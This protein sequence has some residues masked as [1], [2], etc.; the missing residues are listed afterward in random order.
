MK[1]RK[2]VAPAA[3]NMSSYILRRILSFIL[4]IALSG[5]LVFAQQKAYDITVT[6]ATIETVFKMIEQKGEYTISFNAADINKQGLVSF[7][8]TQGSVRAVLDKCL[9]NTNL[10]YEFRGTAIII[11]EKSVPQTVLTGQVKDE[12]G[13][14]MIGVTLVMKGTQLGAATDA[15]GNY[16]LRVPNKKGGVIVASFVGFKTKEVAYTGQKVLNIN[17]AEDTKM[18]EDVVI[19]GYQSINKNALTSSIATITNKELEKLGTLSIDQMLE[20]K[21]TG[22]MVTN[23]N[24]TPGAAAKVRVRSGGTFTGSREPLWVIDGVI[25]ED[26]VPLSADQIN[27]FDNVNIIGNALTGINPQDIETI[28]VLKD[29]SA[30]AIYGTRAANGVIVISTKRGT[31]GSCSLN[32]SGSTSFVD[33]PRYS[34]FEL[35][36]SKERIDVSREIREKNLGYPSNKFSGVGYEGALQEY[37]SHQ[38]NFG[39]FQARVSQMEV[40]N[41]DW[42]KALYR[43]AINQTHSVNASGGAD[44]IRYY[45]SVGYDNQKG[46]EKNVGLNRVTGR[47]NV[48]L[49]IKKNLLISF[50]ASGSVQEAKYNHSSVK[51]FN[52]AYYNSRTMPYQKENGELYYVQKEIATNNGT[53]IYGNRNILHEMNNSERNVKNQEFNLNAKIK[54][55]I[56]KGLKFQGFASYRSTNNMQDEWIQENTFYVSR[57]RT[58]E[59]LSDKD[60]VQISKY[61]TVPF[62]GLYSAGSVYS[63]SFMGRAELNANKSI[64][65]HHFFTLNLGYEAQSRSSE[66]SSGWTAPGYNHSQGRGFI[67]L[68]DIYIDTNTGEVKNFAYASMIKWLTNQGSNI[69]PNITDE[70]KNSLSAYLI[71]NYSFKNRYVANFNM[72]SDG[73]NAF[74]QYERYK[75]KP[76]WSVSG[77]WN[78]HQEKFLKNK[79]KAMDELALKV[80]YGFRGTVPSATPYMVINKYG[81][82]AGYGENTTTISSYPNA[83]LSW[84]KSGTLNMGLS[85]S[86]FE[87]R[88]SGSFDF[89]YTKG[90]DLLLSRPVSLVNGQ[91]AELYNGGSKVDYS[92]E[93]SLRGVL[94]KTKTFGWS[95]SGNVTHTKENVLAGYT[96][97]GK[98]LSVANYLSGSIYLT[99]FPVDAFY[100]Y[101]FGGLN[102]KGEPTIKGLDSKAGTV[103]EYFK[104]VLTYSG[105]R[106]PKL[107]G[108]FSTEF[109]YKNFSLRTNFSYK[110]GQS[111]RLLALYEGKQNMPMP[112]ENMNA[113]FNNRWREPGDEAFTDIPGLSNATLGVIESTTTSAGTINVPYKQIYE[114]GS[115][116]LWKM[117]DKSDARV[118]KGDHIRW[119]SLTLG[120]NFP[121]RM[122][123]QIGIQR[124]RFNLQASNLGYIAF[125]K[126]LKGQDPEQVAGIGLP[127]LPAYTFGINIAF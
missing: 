27:S 29:A 98:T 72:R 1:E 70:T 118:V 78:V 36:N 17:M 114:S 30:T 67:T 43:T 107:Y 2:R 102:E 49:D 110:F 41:V 123:K 46:A 77:R 61:G 71:F 19:T 97:D 48:D 124:L 64:A 91:G 90:T 33:R 92:Y 8:V 100:S 99:G 81:Y 23:L 37:L 111:V 12:F 112:D 26:P 6:K 42:F 18:V 25:Y 96:N 56:M 16:S 85:H 44:N 82:D 45:F 47:S 93:M 39:E 40:A 73:S 80:S 24:S 120:Y 89:A 119:Q 34:D 52:E 106:T 57:L 63:R 103:G 126:K 11:K 22:L 117:Y 76:T 104:D 35:M 62:G 55:D 121:E 69:Y 88:L 31:K 10:T 74:G 127:T 66:G 21:A 122:L 86:W 79:V 53:T 14:P 115:N 75:F 101:Q 65:N 95:V 60:P 7:S 125:D 68:P 83:G 109:T 32:Y 20:G 116:N 13:D 108:G 15:N 51:I 105:S 59:D 9:A 5:N 58:Y 50:G 28:N 38:I 87:G 84:E 4:V 113:I 54:W 3:K 94:I